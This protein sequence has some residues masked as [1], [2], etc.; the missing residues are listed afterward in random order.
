MSVGGLQKEW[1]FTQESKNI[2]G[3]SG[4][5]LLERELLLEKPVPAQ[6]ELPE[7]WLTQISFKGSN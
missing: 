5:T 3:P 7:R 6:D 2:H 1:L 4:N